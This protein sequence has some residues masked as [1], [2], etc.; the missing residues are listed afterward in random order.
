MAQRRAP[1]L[2]PRLIAALTDV[3][4]P[5]PAR[6]INAYP[7]EL[8]GGMCQRVM[9]AIALAGDPSLLIADEPT[10][11][12]DVTTQSAILA[13]LLERVRARRMA[14][15]LIT[16]DLELARAYAERIVVMHAGQIV[17]DAPAATLFANPR[18]PYSALLIAATPARAHSVDG[19]SRHSRPDARSRREHARLPLRRPLR[20]RRAALP[21]RISAAPGRSRG[22]RFPLLATA[23]S[24]LLEVTGL[25][26]LFP[27]GHGAKLHAVDDVDFDLAEGESLG[28]IGESGSGKSTI[29][30]LIAR[31]A[32]PTAGRIRFEGRDIGA[33]PSRKFAGDVARKSIQLVFQSAGDSLN[34][35]YSAARNIAVGLGSIR[36]DREAQRWASELAGEVGLAPELLDRRPHQLSG[37]QQARVGIA[38]ALACEPRLLLLD[39]PTAPLDVSVQA[40]VLKLIDGI[41]RKRRLSLV[42]VS[43]DLDVVRLM[44]DRVMVLYLGRVAEIGPVGEVLSAPRHPYTRA[45]IAS[46]P[47]SATPAQLPGEATSPID[48]A[49]NACLFA[50]RC[51]NA[52]PE[53]VL[54][55]PQLVDVGLNHQAACLRL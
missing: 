1:R 30:R 4:I 37:G 23:M 16:H 12:L 7:S 21:N 15:M 38:R 48:P 33:I 51:R 35:A 2:A 42:F 52:A 24:R 9:L 17:E 40:T 43:H 19:L 18:H 22:P 34:P 31:L 32:D 54:R 25:R 11:G 36:L 5:D 8:S 6:R 53:C 28:V 49:P 20:T 14:A 10:T 41:R 13:L 44:C 39:E 47:G 26:K 29:A 46:A 45:L 50:S 3:R 55:R 27:A